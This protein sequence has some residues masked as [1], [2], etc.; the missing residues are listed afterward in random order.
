MQGVEVAR[1]PCLELSDVTT[2]STT[3]E[4][5]TPLSDNEEEEKYHGTNII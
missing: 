4:T 1:D 3:S 2:D 5:L